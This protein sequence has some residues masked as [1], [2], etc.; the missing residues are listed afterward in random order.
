MACASSCTIEPSCYD[1]WATVLTE[2]PIYVMKLSRDGLKWIS[3]FAPKA[4]ELAYITDL[5]CDVAEAICHPVVYGAKSLS[6]ISKHVDFK[7]LFL[8]WPSEDGKKMLQSF[9]SREALSNFS[10]EK[11]SDCFSFIASACFTIECIHQRTSFAFLAPQVIMNIACLDS[12]ATIT[13]YALAYLYTSQNL[14]INLTIMKVETI[15]A[16]AKNAFMLLEV[17]GLCSAPYL[18]LLF[19]SIQLGAFLY[20]RY[21]EQTNKHLL[22]IAGTPPS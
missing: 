17:I 16:I 7:W 20:Q 1:H 21:L 22:E 19:S 5:T 13:S 2:N 14:N 15:S 3:A 4:K 12:M 18:C 8:P 10:F 6:L 11:I 9:T